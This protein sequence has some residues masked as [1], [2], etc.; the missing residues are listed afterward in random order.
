MVFS[1]PALHSGMSSIL[2]FFLRFI[3][4]GVGSLGYLF[5]FGSGGERT[6]RSP[7]IF[8]PLFAYWHVISLDRESY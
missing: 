5:S 2:L 1:L 8:I 4:A 3:T 7:E 6:F